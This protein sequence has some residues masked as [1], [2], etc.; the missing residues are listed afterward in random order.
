L[1]PSSKLFNRIEFPLLSLEA[2]CN[3]RPAEK[4]LRRWVVS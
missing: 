3:P 4:N 2:Y 1:R